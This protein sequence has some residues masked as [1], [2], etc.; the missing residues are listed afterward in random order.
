MKGRVLAELLEQCTETMAMLCFSIMS[1]IQVS[2][3]KYTPI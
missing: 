2:E 1:S 3:L